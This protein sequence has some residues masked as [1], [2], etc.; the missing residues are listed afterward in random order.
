VLRVLLL[1][2][3]RSQFGAVRESALPALQ[4][5]IRVVDPSHLSII[6]A[7]VTVVRAR[8]GSVGTLHR[9]VIV[10]RLRYPEDSEMVDQ[11]TS[12]TPTSGLTS[13][14]VTWHS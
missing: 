4:H 8:L 14:K 13:V 11:C 3:T 1:W 12:A 9:D 6:A 10:G 7:D 5:F 2:T